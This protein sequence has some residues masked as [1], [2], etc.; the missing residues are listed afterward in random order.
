[1]VNLTKEFMRLNDKINSMKVADVKNRKR[2]KPCASNKTNQ[3]LNHQRE[4]QDHDH[5]SG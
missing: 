1:M 3:V 5:K 2:D 4:D